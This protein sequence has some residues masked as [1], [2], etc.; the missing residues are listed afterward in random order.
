MPERLGG[1]VDVHPAGQR[2]RDDERRRGEVARAREGMDAALEV[3]VARQHGR[4]DQS[5]SSIAWAIGS[6]S[7]PE[8]PMHVVQP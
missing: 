2:E 7:G 8:L 4:G 6:S 5:L 1:Q 3:A